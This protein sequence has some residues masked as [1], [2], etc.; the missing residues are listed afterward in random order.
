VR[1]VPLEAEDGEPC[2]RVRLQEY[3]LQDRGSLCRAEV[4]EAAYDCLATIQVLASIDQ[5]IDGAKFA[6]VRAP[7]LVAGR[8]EV[9][10]SAPGNDVDRLCDH[11]VGKEGL[12]EVAHVIDDDVRALTSKL[13]DALGKIELAVE[14][15]AKRGASPLKLRRVDFT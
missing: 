15:G 10:H 6:F 4:V 13:D 7:C 12:G 3:R 1:L 11:T 5:D 8:C 2:F 9:R 14:C